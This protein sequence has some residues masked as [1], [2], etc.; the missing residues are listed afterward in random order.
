MVGLSA[1]NDVAS[2]WWIVMKVPSLADARWFPLAA[3]KDAYDFG[4]RTQHLPLVALA[5]CLATRVTNVGD[6]GGDDEQARVVWP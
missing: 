1:E 6:S 2:I 5:F 4:A 3:V